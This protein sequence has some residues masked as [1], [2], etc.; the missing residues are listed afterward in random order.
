[1]GQ[2]DGNLEGVGLDFGR[3]SVLHWYCVCLAVPL[4]AGLRGKESDKVPR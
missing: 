4:V 3:E 2:H 1:M